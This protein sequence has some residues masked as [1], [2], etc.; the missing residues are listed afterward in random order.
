MIRA[1]RVAAVLEDA[2]DAPARAARVDL[3]P[4]ACVVPGFTDSHVHLL[5]WAAARR[6]LQLEGAASEAEVLARVAGACA[7]HGGR[8]LVGAGWLA[9]GWTPTRQ[10]LDAV[11]G[12]VP[13]ALLAHDRH[14]LWLNS[15][16][17][18]L[19][20][21]DLELPGGV[22]E[23][24]ADGE[25]TGVLREEAAWAF[26]DRHLRPSEAELREALREALPA[27]AARGVVA[28]HDMD[29]HLGCV[30]VVR[31]L[32][33]R[34]R[35]PL[36]VWHSQP[37][38]WLDR[39]DPDTRYVKAY[40]DGAL[41]S[42]TARMLGGGGVEVT[43]RAAFEGIVR[44]AAARRLPVAVHAIGDRAVRDALDAFAATAGAWRGLRQRIEHAQCVHP[45]DL[46][47][48]AVLGVTASI[49]PSMAVTDEPLARARWADRLDR[50][51]PYRALH[52]A[53]ARLAGGSDAP[54][55]PLDPVA[56]MRAAVLDGWQ[57][58][59]DAATALHAYTTVPAWLEGAARGR[60]APGL[61]ADLV[62]LDRDPL[63]DLARVQPLATMLDG[64]WTHG[65]DTVDA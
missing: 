30:E 59:L 23:R 14:S 6:E 39:L 22:V 17:L 61:P 44:R 27:A 26:R 55:E 64:E 20:R 28:V 62:V 42:G 40:L 25:P 54:I 38:A 35:L 29:G 33:A 21:G 16:A 18:A 12:D 1:G 37:A 50:A 15:A 5:S 7:G 2:A 46:P 9:T 34:D 43:S 3:P 65:G 19:A 60:L 58:P 41:G 11:S 31:A 36:R 56:G 4:D 48:F 45:D 13:V 57:P 32:R 51:Y 24:D 53:G 8:A 47:R 52:D 49:Q 10:A 63:E